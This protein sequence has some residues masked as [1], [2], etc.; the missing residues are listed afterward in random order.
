MLVDFARIT[1]SVP[2]QADPPS[3]QLDGTLRSVLLPPPPYPTDP[4]PQSE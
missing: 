1:H 3:T 4:A 2:L